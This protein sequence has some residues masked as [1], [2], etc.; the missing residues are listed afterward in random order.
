MAKGKA[1]GDNMVDD[2]SKRPLPRPTPADEQR[3]RAARQAM[4]AAMLKDALD[5]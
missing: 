1:L 5:G 4:L 3:I 2:K